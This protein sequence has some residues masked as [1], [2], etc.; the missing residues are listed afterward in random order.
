MKKILF[1]I[2]IMFSLLILIIR[3]TPRF[4]EIFLGTKPHSGIS[5][6]SNPKEA[7]VFLDNQEIGKTPYE[8]KEL[9]SKEYLVKIEKDTLI[10]Q[11]KIKLTPGTLTVINRELS[12]DSSSSA[13]EILTLEKGRGIIVISNP[14]EAEIEIDGKSYGKTPISINLKSGEHTILINRPNYLKRSIKATLPE[15]YSLTISADLAISEVDLTNISTPIITQTEEVI[16]TD[17]P[18]GFLRVRDQPSTQGKV[19]TQVKP[20]DILILLEELSDWNRVRLSD[21]TE[22]Y[23]SSA[24]TEKSNPE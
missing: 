2:L 10:W 11:G 12:K 19:I 20:G 9:T 22:G 1:F 24:Y 6:M 23:V 5:V 7:T 17:T 4:T 3:F 8:N 18:T 15:G 21:G 16:V 13:G 14:S